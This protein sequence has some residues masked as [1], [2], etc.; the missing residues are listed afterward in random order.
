MRWLRVITMAATAAAVLAGGHAQAGDSDAVRPYVVMRAGGGF[1]RDPNKNPELGLLSPL[2]EAYAAASVGANINRYFG[3]EVATDFFETNLESSSQG[4][5][6]E[7]AVWTALGQVRLRY[8]LWGG[9]LTP[10]ALLGGGIL[11]A[12]IND[13]NVN[14]RS[15]PLTGGSDTSFVGSVGLGIEYFI[16][17]NMALG[18]EAKHLFLAETDVSVAGMDRTLDMSTVLWSGGLRIY[19]DVED[20]PQGSRPRAQAKDSSDIRGY[21]ALR[22]GGAIFTNP[23]AAT[24]VSISNSAK[25]LLGAFSVGV[26]LGKYWGL[27][28]AGDATEFNLTAPGFGKVTEYAMWTALAQLRL[29]YPIMNDRL[30][31]YVVAG[32]GIGFGEVNDKLLPPLVFNITGGTDTTY[33][34]AAGAGLEYFVAENVAIGFEAKHLFLFDTD[35]KVQGTPTSLSLDSVALSAGLRLFFP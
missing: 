4:K 32:G 31:P 35:I 16:A 12:E 2:G 11:F 19:F 20:E 9:R 28:I 13:F 3:F 7:Y 25:D 23:D 34:G 27:E 26:N 22:G 21:L 1:L 10:Y 8:P 6:A 33:I 30:V 15:F 18:L 29:R 17:D 5:I 14:N 24:G